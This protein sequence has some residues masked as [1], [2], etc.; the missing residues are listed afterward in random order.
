MPADGIMVTYYGQMKTFY[1]ND[2]SNGSFESWAKN[3]YSSYGGMNP[4]GSA[5][6]VFTAINMAQGN[7]L[8][9]IS[10]MNALSMAGELQ[11]EAAERA[12]EEAEWTNDPYGVR[13]MTPLMLFTLIYQNDV[14]VH[15]CYRLVLS[16]SDVNE[17]TFLRLVLSLLG[18]NGHTFL[19]LVLSIRCKISHIFKTC[20]VYYQM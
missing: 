15:T 1:T 8:N 10:I 16:F 5:L 9:V 17:H 4:C 19:R 18:V 7:V 14:N 11:L 12:A 13:D 3:I 2:F 20:F 6:S